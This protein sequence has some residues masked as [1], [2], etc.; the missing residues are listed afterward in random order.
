MPLS[1]RACEGRYQTSFR[2]ARSE[3]RR[4]IR[5]VSHPS[6]AV[7][8][9][10]T[11]QHRFPAHAHC[12]LDVLPLAIDAE[13][14]ELKVCSTSG[15]DLAQQ[16]PL[17]Q[18]N[19]TRAQICVRSRCPPRP[20]RR[21]SDWRRARPRF[22]CDSGGVCPCSSHRSMRAWKGLRWAQRTTLC[23]CRVGLQMRR[24]CALQTSS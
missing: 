23:L 12:P 1:R 8:L 17:D 20:P 11:G 16:H 18:P 22:A 14:W 10:A 3:Q 9:N 21:S 2:E 19:S 4:E 15:T 13:H 24:R 6:P 5:P 7:F